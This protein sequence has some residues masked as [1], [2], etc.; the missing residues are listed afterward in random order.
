[1]RKKLAGHREDA[2]RL[3]R[4]WIHRAGVFLIA[5]LTTVLIGLIFYACYYKMTGDLLYPAAVI[6]LTWCFALGL[7]HLDL[8]Q[9]QSSLSLSTELLCLSVPFIFFIFS[10][11]E[12]RSSKYIGNLSADT[13]IV[14]RSFKQITRFLFWTSFLIIGYSLF[15]TNYFSSSNFLLNFQGYDAKAA[16]FK[17]AE[18]SRLLNFIANYFPFCALNSFFELMHTQKKNQAVAYNVFVIA[19]CIF[20]CWFIVVSRGTLIIILLGAL[21]IWYRKERPPLRL[22]LCI[23][24]AI[25]ILFAVLMVFR[26]SS[27]SDVYSGSTTSGV[28]NSLIN[29][30]IYGFQNLDTLI[31]N[32]SP[33][34]LGA[35]TFSTI[36]KVLGIYDPSIFE[37]YQTNLFN[38][39][40][41]LYGYFHD[42]GLPG[43]LVIIGLIALLLAWCYKKALSDSYW[44]LFL[45]VLQKAIFVTFFENNF[46]GSLINMSPYFIVLIII[47]YSNKKTR[48]RLFDGPV[49]PF[50]EKPSQHGISPKVASSVKSAEDILES[51]NV[52]ITERSRAKNPDSKKRAT[53]LCANERT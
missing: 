20:Y 40:T 38:N 30:F 47:W 16:S 26:V 46:F 1:M 24:L 19:V 23:L 5:F 32:G 27:V 10:Y 43:T 6:T 11:P 52:T 22:V 45:A 3:S 36:S 50:G 51:E 42:F 21:Y 2:E 31:N 12:L 44:I 18:I 7:Y 49:S 35:F 14:S 48:S 17:P 53:L 37:L 9:Y 41:F 25:L 34:T 29:Y 28:L 33:L 13:L 39:R 4:V 15:V 8:G